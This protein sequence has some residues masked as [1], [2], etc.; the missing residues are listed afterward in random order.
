MITF[1][2]V[3]LRVSGLDP[4]RL[5]AWIAEG[6]V[7]PERHEGGYVFQEI[8]VARCRLILELHED[9]EVNEAAMPVVLNLLDRLHQARRQLRR[10]AEAL[11]QTRAQHG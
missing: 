1:E 11:E 5:E 8:D 2:A 10:V 9:L 6:W 4:A 3:L 7:R